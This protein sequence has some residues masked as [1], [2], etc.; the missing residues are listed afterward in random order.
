L[1]LQELHELAAANAAVMRAR[2]AAKAA[3]PQ[4]RAERV[5]AAL[6]F[7]REKFGLSEATVRKHAAAEL[8]LFADSD[9]DVAGLPA[10]GKV[11]L[12]GASKP[13]RVLSE[14]EVEAAARVGISRERLEKY[15]NR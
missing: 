2:R 1:Q 14:A 13:N 10:S 3:D 12:L 7:A 9:T 6:Q 11:A 15:L 8:D 5:E 4:A